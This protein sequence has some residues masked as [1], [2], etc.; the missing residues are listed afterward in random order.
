KSEGITE[1]RRTNEPSHTRAP[2]DIRASDF[3]RHWSFV[4][5]H[6][7]RLWSQCVRKSERELFLNLLSRTPRLQV[8]LWGLALSVGTTT[9]SENESVPRDRLAHEV[10][11]DHYR[12]PTGPWSIHVVRVPRQNDQFRLHTTHASGKAVGL[13]PVTEQATHSNPAL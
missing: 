13:A 4:I 1:I 5:R 8:C 11:Y 9:R 6:L 2:F 12:K 10:S 7:T 3:F